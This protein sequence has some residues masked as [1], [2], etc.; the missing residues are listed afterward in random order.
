MKKKLQPNDDRLG[1]TMIDLDGYAYDNRQE[2]ANAPAD[3]LPCDRI[4]LFLWRGERT[5]QNDEERKLA[6]SFAEMHAK[7]I[8]N[9]EFPFD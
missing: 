7:G 3:S 1:Y 8:T 2:F 9:V 6:K 5:P 4:W